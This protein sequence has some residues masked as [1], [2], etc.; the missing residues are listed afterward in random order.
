MNRLNLLI[1][2][3]L[4]ASPFAGP[5]ASG[6]AMAQTT[7]TTM[8]SSH[9]GVQP[10]VKFD[11]NQQGDHHQAPPPALPGSQ[12]NPPSAAPANKTAADMPPNDA[13]F[14]AINRGD[15]LSARDA[16][17]R[18]ADPNARNVLGMTPLELAVDLD[19]ND[20][21]FLLLSMR[22]E[23]GDAAPQPAHRPGAATATANA[24]ASS[25]A[26]APGKTAPKKPARTA[27]RVPV[28]RSASPAEPTSDDA[29]Q[30]APQPPAPAVATD[31]GSPNP[32]AGFLG[33]QNR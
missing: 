15:V 10:A 29:S 13:L 6:P 2:A 9:T 25:S 23:G 11:N 26:S 22:G 5:F 18:G 30:T 14:D 33:F 24:A 8:P 31:G 17:S 7:S 19:R 27:R 16:I 21:S 32:Q 28:H 3:T 20:I 4:V 12:A 1:A